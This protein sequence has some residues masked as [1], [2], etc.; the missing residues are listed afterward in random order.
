MSKVKST[1]FTREI[2]GWTVNNLILRTYFTTLLITTLQSL[3][4]NSE[5]DMALMDGTEK[6]KTNLRRKDNGEYSTTVTQ[7]ILPLPGGMFVHCII[8]FKSL[9]IHYVISLL[10][11][12]YL[13]LNFQNLQITTICYIVSSVSTSEHWGCTSF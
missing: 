13:T 10:H 12:T 9:G 11:T 8:P 7:Y 1:A 6:N 2:N 5:K 3:K 4:L